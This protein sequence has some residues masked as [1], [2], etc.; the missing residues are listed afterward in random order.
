M[1]VIVCICSK[2]PNPFLY[3]CIKRLYAIQIAHAYEVHVVDSGSDD[4]AN[5]AKVSRD[6]P[7]VKLHMINN[8]NYEYGAWKYIVTNYQADIYLC[9]QD[10]ILIHKYI[11]LS[12][13]NDN[14]AYMFHCT[15]GFTS[16]PSIKQLG[17]DLLE[18]SRLNFTSLI[19]DKFEL[20]QHCSFI[21]TRPVL[22]KIFDDLPVPPT[23]KD[24]SCCYERLFGLFFIHHGVD[25]LDLYDFMRKK[26]GNRR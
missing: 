11:D 22:E 17:V 24:G 18:K 16:H 26:H 19:D 6:F 25:T 14:T 8:K 23:K 5:Y 10:T 7:E 13:V 4:L 20:C 15:R 9:I 21:V 12:V 3:K 1:N 2:S